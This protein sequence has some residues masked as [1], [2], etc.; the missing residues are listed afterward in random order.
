M[1]FLDKNKKQIPIT[2]SGGFIIK[3]Q[4]TSLED[5]IKQAKIVLQQ[6]INS[7]KNKISHTSDLIQ[8]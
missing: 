4:G 3:A 6:A 7:G 1:Q 8:V 5:A 2:I